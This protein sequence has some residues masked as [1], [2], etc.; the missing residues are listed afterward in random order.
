M[1]KKLGFRI[2]KYYNDDYLSIH[3]LFTH[4]RHFYIKDFQFSSL[5]GIFWYFYMY[6]I[7]WA[8]N[9]KKR[10][11][12]GQQR[13][14]KCDSSM[15][16]FESKY[17]ILTIEKNVSNVKKWGIKLQL[18]KKLKLPILKCTIFLL[19]FFGCRKIFSLNRMRLRSL[20]FRPRVESWP[21]VDFQRMWIYL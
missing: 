20:F 4:S 10:P 15:K 6:F 18:N 1:F 11:T 2:N 19:S 8:N 13:L 12:N 21:M 5:K 14:L 7:E 9:E 3:L 16:I 17:W